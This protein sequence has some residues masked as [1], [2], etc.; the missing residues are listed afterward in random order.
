MTKEKE[1]KSKVTIASAFTSIIWP[2]RKLVFIGLILIVIGRLASL[3]FLALG[4]NTGTGSRQ[5]V[6]H[7]SQCSCRE[8][9]RYLNYSLKDTVLKP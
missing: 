2:R 8:E 9:R 3:I 7:L 6:V 5:I 4:G 1:K